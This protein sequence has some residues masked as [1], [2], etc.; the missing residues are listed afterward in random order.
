MMRFENESEQM[1]RMM[2]VRWRDVISKSRPVGS[3]EKERACFFYNAAVRDVGV[4]G[5]K[6]CECAWPLPQRRL[7][8]RRDTR[9]VEPN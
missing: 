9:V 2:V 5:I 4:C 3:G 1:P 6:G 8:M 7:E